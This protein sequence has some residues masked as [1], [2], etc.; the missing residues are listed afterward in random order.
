M[1]IPTTDEVQFIQPS[2]ED[3]I[4]TIRSSS[5]GRTIDAMAATHGI[6]NTRETFAAHFAE[7]PDHVLRSLAKNSGGKPAPYRGV[8]YQLRRNMQELLRGWKSE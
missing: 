1:R 3:D 2:R 8:A 5:L 7:T 4:E 6:P